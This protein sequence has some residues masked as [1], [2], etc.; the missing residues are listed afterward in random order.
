MSSIFDKVL[1]IAPYSLDKDPQLSSGAITTLVSKDAMTGF[2]FGI[3]STV[4]CLGPIAILACLVMM[5]VEF[6]SVAFVIAIMMLALLPYQVLMAQYRAKL[7]K[8]YLRCTDQRSKFTLNILNNLKVAKLYAW[9]SHFEEQL[10]DGSRQTELNALRMTAV[11]QFVSDTVIFVYPPSSPLLPSSSISSH[12]EF[13][14]EQI[15]VLIS[16]LTAIH[17]PYQLFCLGITVCH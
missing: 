3:F 1:K 17:A 6:G 10:F 15:I 7:Q 4:L 2:S 5:W 12:P 13:T 8:T 14:T 16:Y 11:M 9:N